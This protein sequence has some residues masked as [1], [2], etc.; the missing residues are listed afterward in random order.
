MGW[1]DLH[2][3]VAQLYTS[4]QKKDF[5]NIEHQFHSIVFEGYGRIETRHY[6]ITGN[7]D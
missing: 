5:K 3:D 6:W 7:T 2:T 1:G 4:A